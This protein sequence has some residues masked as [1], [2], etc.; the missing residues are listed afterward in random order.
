MSTST[1]HAVQLDAYIHSVDTEQLSSL[2][3][4]VTATET[5]GPSSQEPDAAMEKFKLWVQGVESK[6][7]VERYV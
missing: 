1:D 3:V 7:A 5:T 2:T 6:S 4:A